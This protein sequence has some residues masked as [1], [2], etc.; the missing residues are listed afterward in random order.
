MEPLVV[1]VMSIAYKLASLAFGMMLVVGSVCVIG[2]I[3]QILYEG[4]ETAIKK[5]L[6]R[7]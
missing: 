4:L 5:L 3:L 2:A 6:K 7:N 1:E